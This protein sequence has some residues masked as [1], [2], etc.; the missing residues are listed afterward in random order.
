M[1]MVPVGLLARTPSLKA[2]VPAT[3]QVGFLVLHLQCAPF[4]KPLH[5][6]REALALSV[7]CMFVCFRC[8]RLN[9][10]C[11]SRRCRLACRWSQSKR[12]RT[13]IAPAPSSLNL[14]S[15]PP[16][17]SKDAV[18]GTVKLL[19][20]TATLASDRDIDFG[21]R[22]G[23]KEHIGAEA[24]PSESYCVRSSSTTGADRDSERSASNSAGSGNSNRD[25]DQST[26]ISLAAPMLYV[27]VSQP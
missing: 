9:A 20:S 6:R 18:T 19:P 10:W 22:I 16:A 1:F 17:Y 2:F 23:A 8:V 27:S 13:R 11:F 24:E 14:R 25:T 5:N 3:L 15:Q 4:N 21:L 26:F 7:V 12:Q